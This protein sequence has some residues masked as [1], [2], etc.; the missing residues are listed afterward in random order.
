M[1][2]TFLDLSRKWNHRVLSCTDWLVS[3]SIV[4]SRFIHVVAD[5]SISYFLWVNNIPLFKCTMFCLSVHLLMGTGLLP[6]TVANV[7]MNMV[8][9]YVFKSHCLGY[10]PKSGIAGSH[11]NCIFIF[12]RNHYTIFYIA[13]IPFIY[14]PAKHKTSSFTIS[15]LTLSIFCFFNIHP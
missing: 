1:N 8:N 15:L 11:Y 12:L 4:P 6:M 13:A 10:I 5:I 7:T 2:S 14:T 9:K 3:L